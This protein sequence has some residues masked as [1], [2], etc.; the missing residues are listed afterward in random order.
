MKFYLDEHVGN[1]VA[2]ALRLRG[3]DVRTASEADLRGAADQHH[4]PL[5]M[6]EAR[7]VVTHDDDF[8]RL[9][10][11]GHEHHGII[12]IGRQTPVGEVIRSLLMIE[13]V[14]SDEEMRG[15]VEFLPL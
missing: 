13:A 6:T 10:S 1:A 12:F 9:H 5:A 8:L 3:V 4:L 11:Q 2:R 7:V 15:H 14:L